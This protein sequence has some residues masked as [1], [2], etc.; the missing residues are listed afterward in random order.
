MFYFFKAK[1][2]SLYFEVIGYAEDVLRDGFKFKA[3]VSGEVLLFKEELRPA[4]P[5]LAL[6]DEILV[7]TGKSSVDC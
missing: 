7:S 5:P 4:T 2:F 3:E 6:T 1:S